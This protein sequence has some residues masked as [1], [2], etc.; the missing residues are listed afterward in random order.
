MLSSAG[1]EGGDTWHDNAAHEQAT[2]SS[3]ALSKR[4]SGLR[5]IY[6][7]A[8]VVARDRVKD[9]G[10]V[11]FAK[12]VEVVEVRTQKTLTI[13]VTSFWAA[14]KSTPQLM[15][16][17]TGSPLAQ[18]LMNAQVGEVRTGKIGQMERSYEVQSVTVIDEYK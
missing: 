1:H 15:I 10:K 17:S 5:Q 12:M 18:L 16:V 2:L 6:T 8:E 11:G 4:I 13:K 3:E 9:D 7:E 14:E